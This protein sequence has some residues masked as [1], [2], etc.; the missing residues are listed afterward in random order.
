MA[1]DA[2]AGIVCEYPLQPPAGRRRPVGDAHLPRVERVSDADAS[3]LVE[4]HPPRPGG[5]VQQGVQDGPVGH[6]VRAVPHRLRLPK[7]RRHR[8]GIQVVPSDDH[9][10]ADL[11]PLHQVVQS[12]PEA[13]T[14]AL[15]EP[16]DACRQSL[17]RD[18]LLRQRDPAAQR[19]V[20]RKQLE[21]EAIG[22]AQLARL[23]RQ[24]HP[25]EGALPLAEQRP[26]VLRDEA[27]DLERV[28][29]PGVARLAADVVAVVE[30]DRALPLQVE[31]RSHVCRDGRNGAA[32]VLRGIAP[33]Q[34][35]RLRHREPRR[36]VPVQGI[37][38]RRLVGEDVGGEAA[39]R[40]LRHHL[41]AVANQTDRQ[42]PAGS[43]RLVAP[44]QRFVDRGRGPVEVAGVE[45]T[46]DACRVDF[47][48]EADGVVH[49]RCQG[50]CAAHPAEPAGQHD[51]A[52]EGA[53]EVAPRHR[54]ERFVRALQNPLR[55]DVDPRAR[56]HLAVHHETLPLE[57]AEHLP[58]RPAT[59]QVRIGDQ[60]ARRLGVGSEHAYRLARLYQESLVVFQRPE[61]PAHRVERGPVPHRLPRAAVHHEILGPLRHL[62][63]QVV[64]EHPQR[65]LLD[66]A[67]AGPLRSPRRAHDSGASHGSRSC[68]ASGSNFP[69]RTPPAIRSMSAVN[70]RSPA[71]ADTSPRTAPYARATPRPGVRGFRNSSPCAAAS[72]S[73][74]TMR[75]AFARM[76]SAFQAALIPMGTT[77][78][79][80]PSVG[81]DCT[82]AG[83]ASTR[84]SAT[85]AA[86]TIWAVMNPDSTPGSRARNA[87]SPDDR[88]GFTIRSR[89]R[90][91]SPASVA[92]A[93]PRTSSARA[94]GCPWKLPP[95]STSAS[96]T[97]GLSVAAFNST[98]TSR[99][100]KAMPS[101][102]APNTWGEQR[103][104]YASSTIGRKPSARNPLPSSPS[105]I[106]ASARCASGA[107]SP[108]A[109]T[110]PC[111]GTRGCTRWFSMATI[112]SGSS[113]RTP[114]VPRTSTFARNNIIAR[115]ASTDSGSPTPEAWLR[116]KLSCSWRA[117]SGGIRT[118][119]SFP[120]P[121]VT[122]YIATP[123]ATASST[124]RRDR[125]TAS[126]ACRAMVTAALR[127]ATATT[128][129]MD[130][131]RPSSWIV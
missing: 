116:I 118:C 41:G 131:E 92:N 121:V 58:C 105:P 74:A 13:G 11:A 98:A 26:D 19:L 97:S 70:G 2:D 47:D 76:R 64:H 36:D 45:A 106:I 18:P 44:A 7:G 22:A 113:G 115:T 90:S 91:A 93:I 88:S 20:L 57:V 68:Q 112:S 34:L 79:W 107:R 129:S 89:R 95:E 54:P 43:P 60:H 103:I 117:R 4:R 46:L 101:P 51:A 123:R 125:R 5:G 12:A 100:A 53:V 30:G 14:L 38:S 71:R 33:T 77:S 56:G 35:G 31:H 25:A 10:R 82:L 114:L 42:R 59:H 122:P 111:D 40:Q 29:D 17:E 32:Q 127:R 108:D 37:V 78:S 1:R 67:F 49:R 86:A 52:P 124:V 8:A 55:A 80:L 109:P 120:K 21:H 63:I 16:A 50:L 75:V 9:G 99:S 62:G 85:S 128:S 94:I 81:T 66:P 3:P 69:S 23:A 73:I 130:R 24:R 61:G 65:G 110:L 48:D 84:Q 15:A 27:G 102:T 104:E 72:S 119:A 87:G 28:G 83:V 39:A 126:S 96:N 6:R